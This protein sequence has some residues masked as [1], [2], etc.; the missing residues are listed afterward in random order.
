MA[1]RSVTIQSMYRC[2]SSVVRFLL[3]PWLTYYSPAVVIK[4]AASLD[5]SK[6]LEA[7]NKAAPTSGCLSSRPAVIDSSHDAM[8]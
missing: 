8:H 7:Q 4:D 6:L 1:K 5:L 3:Q 2:N